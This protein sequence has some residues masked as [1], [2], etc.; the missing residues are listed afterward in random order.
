[1]SDL[2]AAGYERR[3]LL[4][5]LLGRAEPPPGILRPLAGGVVVTA[6][7]IAADVVRRLW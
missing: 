4:S 7:V 6:L 3:R 1:M 5:A 2:E